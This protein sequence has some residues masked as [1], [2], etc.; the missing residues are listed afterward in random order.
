MDVPPPDRRLNYYAAGCDD[1]YYSRYGMCSDGKYCYPEGQGCHWA[2]SPGRQHVVCC[3]NK[4]FT[5]QPKGWT[6]HL[7]DEK[8]HLC[9]SEVNNADTLSCSVTDRT[10]TPDASKGDP[11]ASEETWQPYVPYAVFMM[12]WLFCFRYRRSGCGRVPAQINPG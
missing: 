11:D 12:S 3:P 1:G 2:M 5:W 4:S 10:P 6:C 9:S 8:G 7:C